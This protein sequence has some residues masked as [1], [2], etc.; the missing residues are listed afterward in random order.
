VPFRQE[1]FNLALSV[2]AVKK[3]SS[4]PFF[5]VSL[6]SLHLAPRQ[7]STFIEF[8]PAAVKRILH[9]FSF[10]RFSNENNGLPDH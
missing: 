6:A 9:L 5:F 7:N 3:F 10:H 4:V 8:S 1:L 2:L